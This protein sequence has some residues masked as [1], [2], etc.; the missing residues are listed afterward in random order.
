MD[1]LL[2]YYTFWFNVYTSINSIVVEVDHE[3]KRMYLSP[4]YSLKTNFY[5]SLVRTLMMERSVL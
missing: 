3:L 5:Y 4:K 2:F 1:F